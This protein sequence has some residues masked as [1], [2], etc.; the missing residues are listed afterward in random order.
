MVVHLGE[1]GLHIDSSFVPDISVGLIW[2]NHWTINEFDNAYGTRIKFDHNYPQYFPQAKSNPQLAWCYPE[3]ALG[4]FRRWF[5]DG[6]IGNGKFANYLT[7]A[8][9]KKELP[10]SFAQRAIAAYSQEGT[11]KTR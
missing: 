5:R 7:N 2:S 6:Y 8:V 9:K 1:N 11:Q 10:Q 4:E 3:G